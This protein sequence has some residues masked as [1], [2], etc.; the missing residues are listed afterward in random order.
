[1]KR[2]KR[3]NSLFHY[4]V[5]MAF[6]SAFYLFIVNDGS[7]N[8]IAIVFSIIA[9]VPFILLLIMRNNKNKN[10]VKGVTISN[11]VMSIITLN[12]FSLIYSIR[13]LVR[14]NRKSVEG[15]E[16]TLVDENDEENRE[17][18]ENVIELNEKDVEL[19]NI[20]TYLSISYIFIYLFLLVLL[21]M[22]IFKYAPGQIDGWF[23]NIRKSHEHDG[24]AII[25][26]AFFA[27]IMI[28]AF[29]AVFISVTLYPFYL[30]IMNIIM[31]N[32]ALKVRSLNSIRKLKY[33]GI[34][35]LTFSNMV[36]ARKILS[37]NKINKEKQL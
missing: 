17:V 3:K 8:P 16:F 4:A 33:W 12:I 35:S 9:L 26:D 22:V 14:I 34:V 37:E 10:V 29:S 24:F 7:L 28:F 31:N 19:I 5:A 32:R 15:E 18:K 27:I 1:M 25:Y 2:K 11:I 30:F 6:V 13:A 21:Y 20:S 36:V 23:E